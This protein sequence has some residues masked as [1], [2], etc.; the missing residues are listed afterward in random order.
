MQVLDVV[1][2]GN[3]GQAMRAP[4]VEGPAKISAS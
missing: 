3:E 4:L 2:A 1:F